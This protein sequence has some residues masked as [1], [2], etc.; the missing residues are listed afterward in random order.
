[1]IPGLVY[2]IY[3]T[4][5]ALHVF[6]NVFFKVHCSSKILRKSHNRIL[7]G[8]ASDSVPEVQYDSCI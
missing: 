1:M 8:T 6:L 4:F 7:L 3:F 2:I 5:V